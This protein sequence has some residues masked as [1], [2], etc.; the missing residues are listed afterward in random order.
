MRCA[1]VAE[2]CRDGFEVEV[3]DPV[4]DGGAPAERDDN[5]LVRG[6]KRNIA[7]DVCCEVALRVLVCWIWWM[8][9][10]LMYTAHIDASTHLLYSMTLV[11][12][13]ASTRGQLP[14]LHLI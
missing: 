14:S 10:A 12:L 11:A 1:P 9:A 5:E 2:I 3:R 6:V 4:F 8:L 7:C 13:A